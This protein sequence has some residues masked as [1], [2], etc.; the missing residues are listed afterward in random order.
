MHPRMRM[1][2]AFT[3]IEIILSLLILSVITAFLMPEVIDKGDQADG[4]RVQADLMEL[5]TAVELFRLDVGQLAGDIEDLV[6]PIS[7]ADRNIFGRY[8]T[9]RDLPRWDG[10]YIKTAIDPGKPLKT[11]YKGQIQDVFRIAD[12]SP[13]FSS[14]STLTLP[15]TRYTCRPANYVA[16]EIQNIAAADFES[17]NDLIDG[18]DELDGDFGSRLLGQLRYTS[19]ASKTVYFLVRPCR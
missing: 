2:A 6:E 9:R 4:P 15:A 11:A 14:D 10:P 13:S 17:L 3:L 5:A 18:E 12:G 8:F 7:L 19:E 16:I 1:R